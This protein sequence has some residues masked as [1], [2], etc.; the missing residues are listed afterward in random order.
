L[1]GSKAIVVA[2]NQLNTTDAHLTI[3]I[4]VAL[5]GFDISSRFDVVDLWTEPTPPT[6]TAAAAELEAWN[7]VV[8]RDGQAGGG[9][10]VLKIT[11][12]L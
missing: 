2:A 7:V 12:A 3:N 11:K 8:P 10:A 6:R 4:S 9:I 5:M 1:L